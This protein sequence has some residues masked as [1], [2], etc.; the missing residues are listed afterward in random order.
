[1]EGSYWEMM[2]V[3][4]DDELMMMMMIV[5]MKRKFILTVILGPVKLSN[6]LKL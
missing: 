4:V 1:M 2:R 3:M 5:M 6:G